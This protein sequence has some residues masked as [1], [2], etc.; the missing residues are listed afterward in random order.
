MITEPI[1][2]TTTGSAGSA[3]GTTDST[4]PISGILVGVRIDYH[5]SAPATTDVTITELNG[6]E[7]TLL[8]VSN[9]NSDGVYYPFVELQDTSGAGQGNYA[10]QVLSSSR[11]RV[12]VAQAD[13]LTDAVV[14]TLVTL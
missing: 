9:T 3:S 4:L 5:A 7:R 13:A 8:T 10:P 14:V 6:L 1:R 2:V 12:S 11:I